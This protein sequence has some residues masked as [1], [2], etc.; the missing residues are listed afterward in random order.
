MIGHGGLAG[1]GPPNWLSHRVWNSY[2]AI[3]E[4]CCNA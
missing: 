1:A 2:D 3:V 4:A